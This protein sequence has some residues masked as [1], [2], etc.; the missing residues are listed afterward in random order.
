[1][2]I[3]T[4]SWRIKIFNLKIKKGVALATSSYF[5]IDLVN[6]EKFMLKSYSLVVV[7]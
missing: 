2:D 1:M 3:D 7:F 6:D 5:A 4:V